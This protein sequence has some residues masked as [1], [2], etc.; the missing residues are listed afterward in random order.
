MNQTRTNVEEIP[1]AEGLNQAVIMKTLNEEPEGEAAPCA[2]EVLCSLPEED[3]ET[4]SYDASD[5]TG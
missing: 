3:G 2:N 1:E 5:Y 4:T